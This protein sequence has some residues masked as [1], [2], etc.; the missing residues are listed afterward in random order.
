VP[1]RSEKQVM[2]SAQPHSS[3]VMRS[4]PF[5]EERRIDVEPFLPHVPLDFD[6]GPD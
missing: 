2:K 5:P 6:S 1:D 4:K 3:G